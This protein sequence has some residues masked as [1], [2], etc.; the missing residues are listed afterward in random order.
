MTIPSYL[1]K[2][3]HQV[4]MFLVFHLLGSGPLSG[5]EL[6]CNFQDFFQYPCSV[7]IQG[8]VTSACSLRIFFLAI[9]KRLE[10]I[11]FCCLYSWKAVFQW[12]FSIFLTPFLKV[13]YFS[14]Y[15][16]VLGLRNLCMYNKLIYRNF[17]F[18]IAVRQNIIHRL[19]KNPFSSS[20][21]HAGISAVNLLV[22]KSTSIFIF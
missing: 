1:I 8:L 6:S 9:L 22:L 15:Y 3:T 2:N 13:F 11:S 4:S 17:I 16:S 12:P 5:T 7:A 19:K 10:N 21:F 18:Y 20:I 14:I